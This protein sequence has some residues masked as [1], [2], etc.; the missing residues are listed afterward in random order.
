M[1]ACSLRNIGKQLSFESIGSGNDNLDSDDPETEQDF[2]TFKKWLAEVESGETAEVTSGD[3]SSSATPVDPAPS[4]RP[5]PMVPKVPQHDVCKGCKAPKP[6]CTSTQLI[7][8]VFDCLVR[9]IPNDYLAHHQ[10][11]VLPGYLH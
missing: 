11:H 2:E 4:D 1:K 3:A 10:K 5:P 7:I 6:K 8:Y 9:P